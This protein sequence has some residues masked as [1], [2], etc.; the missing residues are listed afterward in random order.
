VPNNSRNNLCHGTEEVDCARE[1]IEGNL[2]RQLRLGPYV[3]VGN[4][5]AMEGYNL[6]G[7]DR[8][9]RKKSRFREDIF[10]SNSCCGSNGYMQFISEEFSAA[11]IDK[12]V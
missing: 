10:T 2:V 1:P 9:F 8:I 7:C 6:R 5:S 12:L 3:L 4:L 11:D